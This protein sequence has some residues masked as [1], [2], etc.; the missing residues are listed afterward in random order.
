MKDGFFRVAAATPKVKV[1]EPVYNRTVIC[2]MI[3]EGVRNGAGL[4]VFPELCL[5]GCT[6]GD[7]FFQEVLIR[8]AKA[9]LK[10]I[11]RFTEG[12]Q[13]LVFV[14]LPWEHEGKLYNA[15]AAICGGALLGL[16]PK[17]NLPD[18]GEFCE[19]RYFA[20]GFDEPVMTEWEGRLIP[21]GTRLLFRCAD[22]PSL[23]AGAEV[24]QDLW[25]PNPPG[26]RHVL[27]GATVIVNTSASNETVGRA[28]YCRSLVSTQSARLICG[29]VYANAGEGES[30]QDLV[31]GG[32]NLIAE[33]GQLLAESGQFETGIIYAD[34]D[35]EKLASERRKT[36]TYPAAAHSDYMVW[37]FSL[38]TSAMEKMQQEK[39]CRFIDSRPFVPEKENARA[40]RCREIFTI[41]AMGLKKRLEHI[42]CDTAV[43]GLSGGLDSTLA[44]LVTARAFD[45][46]GISRENIHGVTMPCFGTTDRTYQNAC[47]MAKELGVTLTEVDIKKS[48][49]QHF[50]DIGQSLVMFYLCLIQR[51]FRA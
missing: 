13:V 26:I 35:L 50:A 20:E 23:V 8:Q 28:E 42:G 5:T 16:V 4:M 2:S 10:E 30:T 27:A 1:A 14:G 22:I 49:T 45:M 25:V 48:V 31:F 51:E 15:A 18:H 32:H 44:L 38:D 6:C 11:L 21:M 43:L 40:E 29:Y 33:N 17:K 37:D 41:Q 34:M 7:L 9:Q 47:R 24:G 12:K 36:T 39:L 19:R 46:L 3:E